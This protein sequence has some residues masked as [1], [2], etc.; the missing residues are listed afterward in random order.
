[1]LEMLPDLRKRQRSEPSRRTPK[2]CRLSR[3]CESH[4]QAAFWDRLSEIWLTKRALRELDRRNSQSTFLAQSN[5]SCQSTQDASD[6]LRCCEPKV[7]KDIKMFAR[8][9]GPDLSD[10]RNACYSIENHAG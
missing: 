8:R 7:L 10:L 2:K 3:R 6:Y 1:M 5:G 9:G 4:Q